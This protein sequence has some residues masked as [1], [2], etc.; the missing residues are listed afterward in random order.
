MREI[1]MANSTPKSRFPTQGNVASAVNTSGQSS[2][3]TQTVPRANRPSGMLEAATA[4]HRAGILEPLGAQGGI[5]VQ[6]E[7]RNAAE[8]GLTERNVRILPPA[9]GYSDFWAGRQPAY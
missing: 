7:G 3:S 4:Q 1:T 2:P 6:S 5:K 9:V 8:A